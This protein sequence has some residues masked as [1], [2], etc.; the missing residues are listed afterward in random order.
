MKYLNQEIE[1]ELI[2]QELHYLCRHLRDKSTKIKK[3]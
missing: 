1:N 3:R 2:N